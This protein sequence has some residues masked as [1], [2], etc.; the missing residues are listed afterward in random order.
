MNDS[1]KEDIA[2]NGDKIFRLNSKN[3]EYAQTAS[4]IISVNINSK[5]GLIGGRIASVN[6][7]EYLS[8]YG[9]EQQV[10][11]DNDDLLLKEFGSVLSTGTDFAMSKQNENSADVNIKYKE[12]FE[13][14]LVEYYKSQI[15]EEVN[16]YTGDGEN[17]IKMQDEER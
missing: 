9:E 3:K 5:N 1:V 13:N 16:K 10:K 7:K 14:A 8:V 6:N 15:R 12:R 11:F 2:E 17:N 4:G